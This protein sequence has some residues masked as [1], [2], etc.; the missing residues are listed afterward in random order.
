[1]CV[2]VH[3][4]FVEFR[5]ER[6][7]KKMGMVPAASFGFA[8]GV[9]SAALGA[10]ALLR[11]DLKAKNDASAGEVRRV[12]CFRGDSSTPGVEDVSLLER[13][14]YELERR[15]AAAEAPARREAS[16]G[17]AKKT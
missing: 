15:V 17:V 12:V 1:M 9:V 4:P 10:W 13:R 11:A 7:C 16:V 6:K 8:A 2:C 5:E 3:Q 14:L